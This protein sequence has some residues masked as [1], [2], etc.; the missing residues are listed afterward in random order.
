MAKINIQNGIISSSADYSLYRGLSKIA[1]IQ[2]GEFRVLGDLIAE[3]YIVSS[4]V[5]NIEYQSLSGS[6][7]FGDSGDDTHTF[8]GNT[9]SGSATSTGSFGSI[10]T[11]GNVG[12]GTATPSAVLHVRGDAGAS[13]PLSTLFIESTTNHGG[14]VIDAENTKQAHVRFMSNGALK[15]QMRSPFHSG[16]NPDSLRFYSWTHAGDVMTLKN[17]G[18]VG[19][20]TSS[21]DRTLHVNGVGHFGST[22]TGVTLADNGGIAS[23]YGLNSAGSHYRPLEL[24]TAASGAGFYQDTTGNVGIGTASPSQKLTVAGTVS[25]S[26]GDGGLELKP[27]SRDAILTY[28][29]RGTQRWNIWNDQDLS[30]VN[31]VLRF[32]TSLG[33]SNMVIK[34]SGEVGIGTTSPAYSL[35]ISGN[36]IL[37]GSDNAA[38]TR[39]NS[40]LKQGGLISPH[41]TNAE[42]PHLLARVVANTG[43]SRIEIGGGTSAY[44]SVKS[45]VFY[46]AANDTTLTGTAALTLDSSQDATF[47]GDVISTKANGVISGSATS[48]GS[49]GSIHTAGNVGI[50]TNA[51]TRV[52]QV[53]GAAHATSHL[54]GSLTTALGIAGSFPDANDSELGPGY[55]VVARDDTAAAKQLQFWKNGSLHSGISTDTNGFNIVGSD[56]NADV[57]VDTSGNVGI[58]ETSP[59]VPLHIK[60]ADTDTVNSTSAGHIMLTDDSGIDYWKMRLSATNSGNLHYDYNSGGTFYTAMS[61][62]RVGKVGI[63]TDSPAT[64]LHLEAETPVLTVKSTYGV[65]DS[66]NTLGFYQGG[67]YLVLENTDGDDKVIIRAY[68]DSYFNGGNVGIGTTSPSV[69]LEV[70]GLTRITRLGA[71]TTYQQIEITDV[72]TTFNGQDPD[73]YMHYAFKSNDST[74]LLDL[75]A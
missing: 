26:S 55:L 12:I 45:I 36:A 74:K 52:L 31:N 22:D 70:N 51:P 6:T 23:V 48:T 66:Q 5:T 4:S 41:Y 73:G 68:S 15:W 28:T 44:N 24:R 27:S 40:T 57:T 58:G 38:I 18:N 10:H 20:G 65:D 47:A 64:L 62:D 3:N 50:G 37:L 25:A 75:N 72:K 13:D 35:D 21:P 69:P 30:G 8:L 33:S 61:L 14:I 59:T 1:T 11:A 39:T 60:A 17:D 46:T 32:D 34:Q 43:A 56:G 53:N 19:I 49:F 9:I 71:A 29:D 16:T 7:I 63:G 54:V 2:D 67:G 42:E